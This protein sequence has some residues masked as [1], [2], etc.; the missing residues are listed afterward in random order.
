MK[1]LLQKVCH[2]CCTDADREDLFQE[3]VI[4][5]RKGYPEH[6]GEAKTK[7]LDVHRV[8][9]NT[10]ITGLRKKKDFIRTYEPGELPEH[11]SYDNDSYAEEERSREL[12]S[13]IEQ[14]SQVEKAIVMLYMED[15][16]YEEMEEIT[17]MSQG[18]LR[19]RMNR[20]KEK[21]RQLTKNN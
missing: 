15:K 3:I 14:L 18:S 11:K 21:L 1:L 6:K 17:G 4:Q 9:I 16:S 10:A 12:Y 20:I 7:H 19:T 13:A 2:A 8:A 5:L